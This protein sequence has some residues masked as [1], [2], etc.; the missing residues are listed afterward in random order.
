MDSVV[1]WLDTND[2]KGGGKFIFIGL[3]AS[4]WK[5]CAQPDCFPT[6]YN[7]ELYSSTPARRA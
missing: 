2:A 1:E 3:I 7:D 5:C 4:H 6:Y